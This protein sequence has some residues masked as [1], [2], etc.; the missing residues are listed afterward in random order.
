MVIIDGDDCLIGTQV[1]SLINHHF[2]K[3]DTWLAWS[4]LMFYTNEN[5]GPSR[6]ISQETIT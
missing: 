4:N 1:F 2:Q 5:I 6:E 3:Y